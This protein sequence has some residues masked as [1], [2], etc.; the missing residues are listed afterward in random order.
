MSHDGAVLVAAEAR[1]RVDLHVVEVIDQRL[2]AV[3]AVLLTAAAAFDQAPGGWGGA[4]SGAYALAASRLGVR[5][6][7]LSYG[8]ASVSTAL[9]ALVATGRELQGEVA[10]VH[11]IAAAA[12]PV[13]E[14][15]AWGPLDAAVMAFDD[16][17][18]G[19]A[20]VI[21]DV[22]LIRLVSSPGVLA[23]PAGR[24]A[25]ALSQDVAVVGAAP[26]D[27]AAVSVW[28][29]GLSGTARRAL[30]SGW[31]AWLIGERDGIPAQVRDVINRRRLDDAL[32]AASRALHPASAI[33][34]H[35][36]VP[37][38]LSWPWPLSAAVSWL[39]AEFIGPTARQRVADLVRIR[40]ALQ[41]PGSE[42]LSFDPAGGGRAVVAS[43]D[44]SSA[45]TVAVLVP[46][47]DRSLGDVPRLINE[48]DRVAA[49]AGAGTVAVSWLGYAT[50]GVLQVAGD[51]RARAGAPALSRFT[52][53]LRAISEA[54]ERITVIG[55]S[56]GT[57]VAGLAARRGLAA[58][59]L[60]L[61]AS[62]G[63]EA[64]QAAELRVPTGHVWAARV[65]TD[66]IQVVFWPSRL[67]HIV[68]L[69]GPEVFGPDPTGSAFGAR[70]FNA[71][72]AYGHSGYYSAGSTSLANL[73]RIVA[74]RPVLP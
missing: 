25:A 39:A 46:G 23:L 54:R 69:P 26:D 66:P 22:A 19:A 7:R 65:L 61:L 18:R 9:T 72:G 45:R 68:G 1:A 11:R 62:P 42:L 14:G 49:A 36:S 28:W 6:R 29:A 58:D 20:R 8:L 48:G 67:A 15:P 64:S 47:M 27:P 30:S 73:G 5:L 34:D 43:G 74:G 13:I 37:G 60:V 41:A 40:R 35:L 10:A 53:G 38:D 57:L 50:P 63:V 2:R 52:V 59:D 56:Y 12:G 33:I 21:C 55:H 44:P 24:E 17:D 70:H 16:A 4:G 51:S 32:A 71:G 3:A 31:G